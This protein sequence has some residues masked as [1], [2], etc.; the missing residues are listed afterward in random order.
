MEE[1]WG[2]KM[3]DE[4]EDGK[5]GSDQAILLILNEIS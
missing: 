3:E 4:D 5:M 1:R 2:L